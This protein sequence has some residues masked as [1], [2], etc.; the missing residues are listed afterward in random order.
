MLVTQIGFAYDDD[1]VD[2][3]ALLARYRTLAGWAEALAAAGAQSTVVHRFHRAEELARAGVRSI[4]R[5][6]GPN[7]AIAAIAG[8]PAVLW[9]GRLDA[10][11]S[12]LTILDGI[13]R[14]ARELPALTLT[15]VYGAGD[16]E[17]AVRSRVSGS[18]WLSA[19]VRLAGSVRHEELAAFYSAADLFTIG[20]HREG[21][22]Y[23]LV[24]ACACGLVPVVTDIPSFRAMTRDGTIGALW[25]VDDG[26]A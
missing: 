4:I 11:K 13:D 25:P 21:S 14:A 5:A 7:R 12:P 19:H 8:D 18:P 16:L 26:A 17:D 20:S 3:D 23:A 1:L 24:E 15:M 22:G 9:V 2:V 6:V 10:N